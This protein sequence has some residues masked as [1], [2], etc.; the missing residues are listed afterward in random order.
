[1]ALTHDDIEAVR[2]RLG[3]SHGAME[4]V[5]NMVTADEGLRLYMVARVFKESGKDWEADV[6]ALAR[7]VTRG[8]KRKG[9]TPDRCCASVSGRS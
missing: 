1:M 5:V 6:P 8:A 7:V 9:F 3:L 2:V 4:H